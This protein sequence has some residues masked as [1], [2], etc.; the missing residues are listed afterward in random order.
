MDESVHPTFL[1][2]GPID[3]EPKMTL[4]VGLQPLTAM[5]LGALLASGS[6]P[7]DPG[8]WIR[9]ASAD[10][11]QR[12]SPLDSAVARLGGDEVKVCY[13]R[14]SAR[15]RVIMGGLVPFG[16]PWRL[17]A[18]EATTLHVPVAVQVGDVNLKP[19]VY[20]LYA[21]PGA[22]TWQIVVNESATRWGIPIDATVRAHD[23]GTVTVPSGRTDAPIEMLTLRLEPGGEGV[24][25]LVAEW[26]R[27]RVRLTVRRAQ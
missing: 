16:E 10:L 7:S 20:S 12:A 9:G 27:T 23:V 26:E 18:N 1:Y 3:K 6:G 24:L 19:G 8:C 21:I 22:K 4:T 11:G 13:S 25:G 17:G 14:P 15:G 2:L 5:M